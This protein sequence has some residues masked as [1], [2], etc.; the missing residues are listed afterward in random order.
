MKLK[1][2]FPIVFVSRPRIKIK[3]RRA[4]QNAND[5]RLPLKL[6]PFPRIGSKI[7]IDGDIWVVCKRNNKNFTLK[8][9]AER[10]VLSFD[11]VATF[12]EN[13]TMKIL[14]L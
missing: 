12:I 14:V 6:S 1:S 3:S 13:E 7:S 11:Y 10:K 8:R 5:E 2:A 9:G 4:Q